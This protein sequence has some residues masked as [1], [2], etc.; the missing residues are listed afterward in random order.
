MI[1]TRPAEVLHQGQIRAKQKA[2]RDCQ[3][4]KKE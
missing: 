2:L 1:F 4:K 3:S